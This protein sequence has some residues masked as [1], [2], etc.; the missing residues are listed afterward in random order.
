MRNKNSV[1]LDKYH[2]TAILS[3]SII[4]GLAWG[5]SESRLNPDDSE[6]I[7]YRK[8]PSTSHAQDSESRTLTSETI[9]N[10]GDTF[11]S[12][13]LEDRRAIPLLNEDRLLGVFIE[14]QREHFEYLLSRTMLSEPQRTLELV[15]KNIESSTPRLRNLLLQVLGESKGSTAMEWYLVANTPPEDLPE[16]SASSLEFGHT[17][18]EGTKV[19]DDSNGRTVWDTDVREIMKG[20]AQ[21]DSESATRFAEANFGLFERID[22]GELLLRARSHDGGIVTVAPWLDS[23]KSEEML[24]QVA[25]PAFFRMYHLENPISALKYL[26]DL[27][28]N[29]P[30]TRAAATLLL[31][32]TTAGGDRAQ[33]ALNA[34]SDLPD[35]PV[36]TQLMQEIDAWQK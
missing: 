12:N 21:A 9:N 35:G 27:P 32:E 1:A 28:P 2:L 31:D 4:A 33:R 24:S 8:L 29:S 14:N 16:T 15:D 11:L 6:I 22:I 18:P 25:Q 26:Q 36:K 30:I 19:A 10:A 7:P 17:I 20:W 23:I 5:L 34:L 3:V 13:L